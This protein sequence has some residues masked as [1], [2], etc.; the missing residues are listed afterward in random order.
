[1]SLYSSRLYYAR[2]AKIAPYSAHDVMPLVLDLIQP[3]SVVDVGCGTGAWLAACQR[4]GIADILGI[5]GDYTDP[6]RLQFPAQ[7]FLPCDLRRPLRLNRRFDLVISLEV[8][9]HLPAACAH[10]FITSL[11]RLGPA[12]LFS[13]AIPGQFGTGH[14]NE[15]WPEYW[16]ALFQQHGYQVIDCIRP[17]IWRNERVAW[18][19]RQNIMLFASLDFLRS[20]PALQQLAARTN[21]ARL[22]RLHPQC[23]RPLAYIAYLMRLVRRRRSSA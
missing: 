15:Q 11:T 16:A 12:V 2:H 19:Y 13:A 9:E 8:A 14:L 20:R 10:D 17:L 4:H 6:D 18:W 21:G 23:V 3:R 22:S 1:M 5:D 7:N